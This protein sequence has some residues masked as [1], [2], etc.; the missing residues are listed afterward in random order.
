MLER[1]RS[2]LRWVADRLKDLLYD[3]GNN[4]LDNGRLM[5]FVATAALLAGEIH[6]ILLK[7]PIDLGPGGLGGGLGAVLTAA[8]V[9]VIKDRSSSQ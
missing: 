3:P 2:I 9:Y 6:N 7:Q 8:V 5:A 1:A 4:H